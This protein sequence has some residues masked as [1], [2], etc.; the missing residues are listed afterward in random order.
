MTKDGTSPPHNPFTLHGLVA[1]QTKTTTTV[2]GSS[3]AIH[4]FVLVTH[5]HIYIY[6][7]SGRMRCTQSRVACFDCQKVKRTTVQR[8]R[9]TETETQTQTYT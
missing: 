7:Y 3:G 9:E 1:R 2:W 5:T 8:D 6:I 4:S